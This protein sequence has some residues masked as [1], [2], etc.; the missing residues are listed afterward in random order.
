VPPNGSCASMPC[1]RAPISTGSQRGQRRSHIWRRGPR[2]S[3]SSK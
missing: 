1:S 2:P 3:P